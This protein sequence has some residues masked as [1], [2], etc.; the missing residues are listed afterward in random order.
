[1]NRLEI[2]DYI[3]PRKNNS[4]FNCNQIDYKNN[5]N[6]TCK[7]C[8]FFH[9]RPC[10]VIQTTPY[11]LIETNNRCTASFGVAPN[12]YHIWFVKKKPYNWKKL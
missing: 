2:G 4:R 3:I 8:D 10:R 9:A 7:N 1:M 11:I 6:P 12:E 5:A